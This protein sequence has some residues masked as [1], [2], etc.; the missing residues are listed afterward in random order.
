MNAYLRAL[1]IL[2]ITDNADGELVLRRD[3]EAN[4]SGESLI[5]RRIVVLQGNLELDGLREAALL[6][7]RVLQD[8]IDSLLQSI[9][10]QF[11]KQRA[12]A[13]GRTSAQ[14]SHAPLFRLPLPYLPST[15]HSY[16]LP[17]CSTASIGAFPPPLSLAALCGCATHLMVILFLRWC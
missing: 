5:L 6:L 15:S 1:A 8:G 14:C 2:R 12:E 9:G 17:C 7:G 13:G 16:I 11:A 4:D 10:R 3:R